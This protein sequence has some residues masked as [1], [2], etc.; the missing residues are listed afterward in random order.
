MVGRVAQAAHPYH[1]PH[2]ALDG[3]VPQQ[4]PFEQTLA[5]FFTAAA[6]VLIAGW[7]LSGARPWRV[8]WGRKEGCSV[9]PAGAC[10][11]GAA[12]A[13]RA[14]APPRAEV[15]PACGRRGGRPQR[16]PLTP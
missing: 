11:G 12:P 4:V 2:I 14:R 16:H 1:P 6:A 10:A 13:Q 5:V 7:K 15:S 8:G 9:R 3:Y